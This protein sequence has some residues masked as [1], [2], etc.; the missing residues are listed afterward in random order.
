MMIRR[1]RMYTGSR[2]FQCTSTGAAM[3]TDEYVPDAT[4]T[5]SAKP[6]SLSVSPPNSIS[7]RIGISVEE[8]VTIERVSTSLIERLTIWEKVARGMRGTFS[9]I[10]SNTMIVS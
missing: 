6:K 1:R 2:S 5:S 8:L 7:A 4:P 9:R 3:N 10:R